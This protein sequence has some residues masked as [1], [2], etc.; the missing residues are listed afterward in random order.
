VPTTTTTPSKQQP[1]EQQTNKS[2]KIKPIN[3][4]TKFDS[5]EVSFNF[6]LKKKKKSFFFLIIKKNFLYLFK[7]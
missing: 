2:S 5:L 7:V 4:A 3:E 1:N 6:Y